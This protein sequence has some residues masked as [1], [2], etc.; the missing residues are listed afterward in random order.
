[1]K[2]CG[3]DPGKT[4]GICFLKD[5]E[6]VYYDI[7]REGEAVSPI[8]VYDIFEQEKP[9]VIVIE[10]Q[11]AFPGQGIVSNTKIV[12][13]FHILL[14]TAKLFKYINERGSNTRDYI[15][16]IKTVPA[17]NWQGKIYDPSW[18]KSMKKERSIL[19]FK[20]IFGAERMPM[21]GKRVKKPH[22]G[23]IDAALI[24]EWY[25]RKFL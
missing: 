24:A 7:P 3:I 9:D 21:A 17:R 5:D 23:Y 2:I 18:D 22:L 25:R 1:M 6:I 8:G 20:N 10:E 16:D 15:V 12:A 11:H 4:G 13:E 14:A 19:S